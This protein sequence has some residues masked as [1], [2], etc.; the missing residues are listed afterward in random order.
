MGSGTTAVAAI[1][2]A[3]NY[4]GIDLNPEYVDVSRSRIAE[5]Q[6]GLPNIAEEQG[7]YQTLNITD[8]L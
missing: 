4:I 8:S 3:R 5:T 2:L 1:Q 6:I 7:D